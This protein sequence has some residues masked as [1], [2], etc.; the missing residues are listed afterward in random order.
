MEHRKVSGLLIGAGML[1]TLGGAGLF[2]LYAPLVANECRT[3]YPELAFLF[4]PGLIYLWIIAAFYCAAMAEYFR[5]CVRIGQ[6]QSFCAQN[7]LGLSRIALCMNIAGSLWVLLSFL[8]GLI[9][10]IAIGP[11]FLIFLLAAA[12]SFALGILAWA[13]GRLLSRAVK[14][15]E[16]NDLTV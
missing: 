15:K 3:M 6:D 13:L 10:G 9:W 2:L 12:A 1:A 11:V 14:L 7:A 4:W 5:V 16:E 8:P